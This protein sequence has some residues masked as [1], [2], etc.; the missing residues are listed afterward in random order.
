MVGQLC[1]YLIGRI[2]TVPPSERG[3]PARRTARKILRLPTL[4][5]RS[6]VWLQAGGEV[7]LFN[8]KDGKRL[9]SCKGHT[10]AVF[11]LAFHPTNGQLA[12]GGF[13]GT[14]RIFD[15]T[16]KA[17]NQF[18]RAFVPVPVKEAALQAGK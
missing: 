2:W 13:D 3:R 14:V 9:A 8:S 16:P 7:R 6:G 10:G 17:T 1:G 5:R 4:A 11:A 12:T 15:T 18:I